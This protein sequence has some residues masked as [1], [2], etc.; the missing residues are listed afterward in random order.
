[1]RTFLIACLFSLIGT[2]A[3][4]QLLE[5]VDW[6]FEVNKNE[7]NTYTFTATAKI[8]KNWVVYSQHTGEGGPRPLKFTYDDNVNTIGE[9]EEM[10][11]AIKKM[12]TLFDVEV[13]QFEKE[14]VFTQNFTPQ[15]GQSSFK[16]YLTFMCCDSKRC[17]PPTDV[18]FDVAL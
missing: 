3:S 11:T 5:P 15:K 17:L 12:S 7:D 8:D 16:G 14:A 4:A 9:T 1:M 18:E 10:S 13:I 6:S 2:F